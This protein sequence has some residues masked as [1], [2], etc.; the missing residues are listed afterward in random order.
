MNLLSILAFIFA[1]M[2]T[3]YLLYQRQLSARQKARKSSLP[4]PP[5]GNS[6][7][8]LETQAIDKDRN[9]ID[10]QN[11]TPIAPDN[12]QRLV[13]KLRK[14][15]QTEPALN[16]CKT[17]FP[18]YSAYRK[19]TVVIRSALQTKGLS[20][21]RTHEI[22][23]HLYETAATAELIHMKR[24]RESAISSA[25]LKKLNMALIRDISFNYSELGYTEIPLLTQKDIKTIVDHWGEP[26]KHDSP[27]KA[28]QKYMK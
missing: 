18:L 13:T 11:Q 24:S 8:Y 19:A 10:A 16:L 7:C 12:W 27:R 22:L 4:L 15:G 2:T 21:R 1:V 3:S 28:Y 5:I 26:K 17:K 6:D 23:L 20:K 9:S 14:E 25:E